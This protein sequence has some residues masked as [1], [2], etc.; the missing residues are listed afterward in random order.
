MDLAV[1]AAK[2]ATCTRAKVG[3]VIVPFESTVAITGYC[4]SPKRVPHCDDI[5]CITLNNHCIVTIHSEI[6]AILQAASLGVS[7]KNAT[8]YVTHFPCINCFKTLVN[9]GVKEIY[10]KEFYPYKTKEEIRY[11][12]LIMGNTSNEDFTVWKS[13]GPNRK[14]LIEKYSDAIK[15]KD[16][17]KE[18]I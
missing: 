17:N 1:Q 10:Y 5:G 4:G 14:N 3:T 15:N 11:F 2:R 13:N 7:I 6:N 18:N 8:V 9:A 12:D 16:E